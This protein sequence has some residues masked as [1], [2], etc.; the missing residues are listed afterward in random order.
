MTKGNFT[1]GPASHHSDE[2]RLG[3]LWQIVVRQKWLIIAIV[4]AAVAVTVFLTLRQRPLYTS[5]ALLRID[6]STAGANLLGELGPVGG[7][8]KGKIETEI[9]VLRSRNLA[10]AVV[11]SLALTVQMVQPV[12]ARDDV[13]R[14]VRAP[15]EAPV[16]LFELRHT[17]GGR[18]AGRVLKGTGVRIPAQ[19]VAG[20]P[21]QAG[22]VTVELRPELS[23][24]PV[25]RVVFGVASYRETVR[26]YRRTLNVL[27]P[28]LTAQ[29]VAIRY[30][31]TDP[32]LVAAVPN[33]VSST[34]LAYKMQGSR[35]EA[36]NTIDYLQ[37]QVAVYEADL[38]SA[39]NQLRSFR[40]A[41]QVVSLPDEAASQVKRLSELQA[42]HDAMV[43]ERQALRELLAR[44]NGPREP[45][46]PSPY[47]QLASF[48][49]FLSNRAIQDI[50]QSLTGLETQKTMLLVRRTENNDE[51]QAIQNRITELERD[52]Y[53]LSTNYLESLDSQIRSAEA[54][55][56]RFAG[57]LE[58]IPRREVE[59]ARLAR[60]QKLIADLN[61]LLQTRLKEAE[62]QEAVEPGDVRVID[63][64]PLPDRPIGP[65][66]VRNLGY[67][68]ALGLLLGLGIAWAREAMDHRVRNPEQVE[69]A[70]SGAPVLANIPRIRPEA[71]ALA[72]HGANGNGNGKSGKNGASS[73]PARMLVTRGAP[74]SAA[75]EAYRALRTNL[76]FASLKGS[77]QV[78]VFTSAMPGDGKSTSA[79]NL[80][81]AMAQQGVR[82][83][84]IDADLRRGTLHQIFEVRQEP[85]LTHV[86]LGH[87]PLE[88]AIISVPT[89]GSGIALD[90]LPTGVLPPNPA[91]LVGSPQ[92]REFVARMRERYEAI[93][94]DA[95]PLALVTDAAVLGSMAD[96]T[97]LVA[98]LGS[99]DK[100]ALH[101]A[102]SQVYNLGANMGGVVLN[103]VVANASTGYQ[104]YGYS[105]STS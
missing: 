24:R 2:L 79:S 100:R 15:R 45:D 19:V 26:E 4:A 88:E 40:E 41:E 60:R 6:E 5:E 16:G 18:Y 50:L 96:A 67:G 32:R 59:F 85:G 92:M 7:A 63:E 14:V 48:P 65:R 74:H 93:I 30:N 103:D 95:P 20:Q 12:G 51:V 101:Y 44:V 86:L 57:E 33:L 56:G 17:G 43:S 9:V 75:A 58:T 11:D 64:A 61:E 13:L 76:T 22:G 84:L 83:L 73:G 66:P 99:T 29:V 80:G 31:S 36:R 62:I 8:G 23:R 21:F 49:V 77:P 3:E 81:M 55:L 69:K 68:L 39:E 104:Y 47:R 94:F 82:T 34:F 28:D 72:G 78:V 53:R 91:E 38:A 52:L 35:R 1:A 105:A 98:R 27:R 25:E 46:G 70:T 71:L 102:A 37:Q 54:S 97:L 87:V 90:V 89:G 10:E 42:E